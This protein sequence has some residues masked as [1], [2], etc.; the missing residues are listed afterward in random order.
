VKPEPAWLSNGAFATS[1]GNRRETKREKLLCPP[2]ETLRKRQ[3]FFINALRE[4][5]IPVSAYLTKNK[6]PRSGPAKR[7]AKANGQKVDTNIEEPKGTQR[8]QELQKSPKER[9][10]G[11]AERYGVLSFQVS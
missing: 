6:K 9:A 3:G 8:Q 2:D 11:I 7:R 4:S 5:A 10:G 1:T